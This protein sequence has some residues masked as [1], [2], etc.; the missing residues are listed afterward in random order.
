MLVALPQELKKT[1]C[2]TST[3]F[4]FLWRFTMSINLLWRYFLISSENPGSCVYRGTSPILAEVQS[5]LKQR[6]PPWVA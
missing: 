6:I 2:L 4:P 5:S 3:E 1:L